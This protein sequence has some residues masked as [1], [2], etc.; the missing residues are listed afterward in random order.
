MITIIF[1]AMHSYQIILLFLSITILIVDNKYI[2]Y[3]T[4]IIFHL[5]TN[6]LFSVYNK[7]I[8]VYHMYRFPKA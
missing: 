7:Y 5:N 6:N 2:G 8:V 4:E 1:I 3:Y